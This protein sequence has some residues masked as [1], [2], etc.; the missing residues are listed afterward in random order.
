MSGI[1]DPENRSFYH[2]NPG[3]LWLN[4]DG[5]VALTETDVMHKGFSRWVEGG[6]EWAWVRR[7]AKD[8]RSSM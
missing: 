8:L 3:A 4:L 7:R 5:S 6:V 1:K 2:P